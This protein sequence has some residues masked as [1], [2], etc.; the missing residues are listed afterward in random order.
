MKKVLVYRIAWGADKEAGIF[1]G[2]FLLLT[3]GFE[4]IYNDNFY[5]KITL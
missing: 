2:F 3:T 1:T 5:L 4:F